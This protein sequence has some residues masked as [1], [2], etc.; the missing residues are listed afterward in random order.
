M[1]IVYF[2]DIYTIQGHTKYK[3]V[4]VVTKRIMVSSKILALYFQ[5]QLKFGLIKGVQKWVLSDN[6]SI[7][8]EVNYL[9][10]LEDKS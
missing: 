9:V 3:I 7:I 1:N 8:F 6:L 5:A 10:V 2:R 4:K